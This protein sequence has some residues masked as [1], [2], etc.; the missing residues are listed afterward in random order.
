MLK[1]ISIHPHKDE[2]LDIMYQ[3]DFILS[4]NP[5]DLFNLYKIDLNKDSI[6]D[7]IDI[8]QLVNVIL[9]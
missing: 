3:V 9:N 2:I 5:I 7:V 4:E 8:M 1:E 6:I